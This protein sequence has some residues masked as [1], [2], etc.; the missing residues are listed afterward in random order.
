MVSFNGDQRFLGE[1]AK[2]QEIMNCKNTVTSLKRLIGRKFEEAD[3]Q[4]SEMKYLFY[5]LV[6]S[7]DGTTAAKV[8]LFFFLFLF[9][10]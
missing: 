9:F 5:N 2:T 10:F 1:G 6:A 3:V 8:N 4:D 7:D